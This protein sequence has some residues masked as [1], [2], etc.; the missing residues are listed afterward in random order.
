[1]KFEQQLSEATKTAIDLARRFVRQELFEDSRYLLYPNQSCDGHPLIE[2]EVIYPDEWL[3][4]HKYHGPW[5]SQK[6]VDYLWRER[7]VPEWID[8]SVLNVGREDTLLR[9]ICCGRYTETEKLFY[10]ELPSGKSPFGIKSPD[11]PP[12]WDENQ[13][14]FDLC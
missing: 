9:L 3:G 10:Y 6:V 12:D 2:D 11:F 7:K 5:N 8:V 14:K 1:M 13:G 4:L